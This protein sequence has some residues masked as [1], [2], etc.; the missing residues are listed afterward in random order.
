MISGS[1]SGILWYI[2]FIGFILCFFGGCIYIIICGIH[3]YLEDADGFCISVIVAG[4][5]G[6]MTDAIIILKALGL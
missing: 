3:G 1:L 5:I 2:L 4:C 6:I